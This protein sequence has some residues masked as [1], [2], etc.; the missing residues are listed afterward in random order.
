MPSLLQA[1]PAKGL[2]LGALPSWQSWKQAAVLGWGRGCGPG[3]QLLEPGGE[4]FPGEELRP[5]E[6]GASEAPATQQGRGLT[7]AQATGASCRPDRGLRRCAEQSPSLTPSHTGPQVSGGE[8][9]QEATVPPSLLRAQ[10]SGVE[11]TLPFPLN[12]LS[13]PLHLGS[14]DQQRE[15][16]VVPKGWLSRE[17]RRKEK[18]EE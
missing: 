1:S 13:P 12:P 10:P 8:G 14:G 7:S 16:R 15:E 5:R 4:A 6:A 2:R 17:G 3:S 11:A 18:G 9:D